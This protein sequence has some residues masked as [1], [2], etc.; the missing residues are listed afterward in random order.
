MVGN[1]KSALLVYPSF[2]IPKKSI[3]HKDYLPI[4]LLKI[5]SYLINVEH[6]NKIILV[7]GNQD[8]ESIIKQIGAPD[9][10]YISSLFTYWSWYFYD[11]L[12]YY[13][14]IFPH[15]KF[16][17]GGIYVSLMSEK[18]KH[19]LQT[20]YPGSDINVHVGL[21]PEAEEANVKYGPALELMGNG[22]EQ[23][24]FIVHTKRG[25]NR[26]C[27]YCGAY[28]LENESCW[29]ENHFSDYIELLKSKSRRL[30]KIVF[31]D[32]NFLENENSYNIL[33]KIIQLREKRIIKSCESQSG[34]DGRLLN[35]DL[36]KLIKKAGFILP[37]I[38]WDGGVHLNNT[39][40]NQLNFLI[41]AG[42]KSRE[43][44]VFMIY[45]WDIPI[46]EMIE[47]IKFCY[48]WKVQITDCR[49]RPLDSDNLDCYN[50]QKI[51]GQSNG[52]YFIHSNW[53]DWQIR[54]FRKLVRKGNIMT[55]MN[56]DSEQFNQW[57]SKQPIKK[58]S[59]GSNSSYIDPD[60]DTYID[61]FVK[62]NKQ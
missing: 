40:N 2:P 33:E 46:N 9:K 14:N 41:K 30:K 29:N 39:I 58:E 5:G 20:R 7:F 32:N 35:L 13:I 54:L 6:Y 37:K 24:Y 53:K 50:P 22:F 4:G 23:D 56:W 11:A 59:L 12:D 3:N 28:L 49:Y 43:I 45:N 42:F 60:I 10:I 36:A 57:K 19:N 47:K 21:L 48:D 1:D 55:R 18:V 34:F 25:C 8:K 27:K 61:A 31:Y 51:L 44:S 62:Q 38:A 26:R 17:V 15:A 52:D 16:F